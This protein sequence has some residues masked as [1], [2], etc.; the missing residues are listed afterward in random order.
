ME[1]KEL[2]QKVA[3]YNSNLKADDARFF[4]NVAV[5][6]SDGSFFFLNH[7]FVMYAGVKYVDD[8]TYPPNDKW[9]LFFTEHH[10][11]YVFHHTD[12]ISM[13]YTQKKVDRFKV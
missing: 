8:D 11:V 5:T 6:H 4:N 12:V 1:V 13:I 9:F 7:A 10:G 3:E 2:N